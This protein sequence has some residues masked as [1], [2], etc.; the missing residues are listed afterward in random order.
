M[1]KHLITSLLM[2]IVMTVLLGLAY[3]LLI[4]GLAQV[5]F[6]NKANGQII[7][8]GRA[9]TLNVTFAPETTGSV[10]GKVTVTSNASIDISLLGSGVLAHCASRKFCAAHE[11]P[12]EL[13]SLKRFAALIESGER[14]SHDASLCNRAEFRRSQR[15]E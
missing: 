11:S 9:V 4:T 3:P 12:N 6:R 15:P 2:T 14:N 1:K 13:Q 5:L 7:T 10:T 8:P